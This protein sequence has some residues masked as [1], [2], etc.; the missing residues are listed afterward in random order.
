MN[1]LKQKKKNNPIMTSFILLYVLP[2]IGMASFVLLG[3]YEIIRTIKYKIPIPHNLMSLFFLVLFLSSLGA[4]LSDYNLID[5]LSP[6]IIA[7]F[8]GIYLYIARR[9]SVLKLKNYIFGFPFTE[10]S[11]FTFSVNY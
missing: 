1:K 2:P 3:I 10:G 8:F 9:S 7:C 5:L 4:T 6:A 11:I